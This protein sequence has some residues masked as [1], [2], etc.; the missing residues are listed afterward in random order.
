MHE[1]AQPRFRSARWPRR[2]L[3]ALRRVVAPPAGRRPVPARRSRP[4]TRWWDGLATFN[5]P[6][7]GSGSRSPSTHAARRCALVVLLAALATSVP[8]AAQGTHSVSGSAGGSRLW[9]TPSHLGEPRQGTPPLRLSSDYS[10]GSDPSATGIGPVAPSTSPPA[11]LTGLT[12]TAA[13]WRLDV[14]WSASA[15]ATSYRVQWKGPGESYSIERTALAISTATRSVRG[16][17]RATRSKSRPTETVWLA[18]ARKR[19]PGQWVP[20]CST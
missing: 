16:Q 1:E 18:Q 20:T 5:A 3:L 9:S 11:A 19:L 14:S 4:R 10:G 17:G 15:N 8:I 13:V 12:L 2:R 6:S 7:A